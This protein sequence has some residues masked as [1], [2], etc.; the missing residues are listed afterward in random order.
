MGYA[1]GASDYLTKPIDRDR[2]NAI[3]KKHQRDRSPK[4]LLLVEDDAPTREMMHRLLEK[5]GWTVMEAENGHI[6]L[7]RMSDIQ[8]ELIL[9][10]LMMPEM[11]GFTFV[12]ELQQHESWRSIPV[13][14]LTARDIT[15]EDRQQ[16][17]GYVENIL[18]KGAYTCEAL[19]SQV[20]QLV[21]DL[22][23]IGNP[24]A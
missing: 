8:P 1:L 13:V 10:D 21:S 4:T 19:L 9:L 11:D 12:H 6:A 20:S 3:L 22:H 16:L 23:S 17:N 15:P 14:V 5:E 18:Q 7:E 2:L 24:K